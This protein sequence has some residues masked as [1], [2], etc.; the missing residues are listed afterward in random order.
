MKKIYLSLTFLSSCAALLLSGC[1][2]DS[3]M[4]F[5]DK[6]EE[7]ATYEQDATTLAESRSR[8]DE[9]SVNTYQ[10]V[11]DAGAEEIKRSQNERE[12]LMALNEER[13]SL[14]EQ[15]QSLRREAF[16]K[17]D[18]QELKDYVAELE[19]GPKRE[20]SRVIEV[21]E[22]R[23]QAFTTFV[24]QYTASMNAEEKLL[25]YLT[26]KPNFVKIDEATADLNRTTRQATATLNDFNRLTARYNE[27][28]PAFYKEVGLNIK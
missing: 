24:K 18:M 10:A 20:G 13:S 3:S 27:L 26:E 17:L 6:L 9:I 8:K 28:K 7:H 1:S 21:I 2:T 15:E 19:T 14:L 12:E 11:L 23:E 25:S 5:Y 22:Q 4:D 16:T